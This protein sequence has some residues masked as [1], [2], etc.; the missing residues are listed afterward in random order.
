[1]EIKLLHRVSE[2]GNHYI[3]AEVK[4][5]SGLIGMPMGTGKSKGA[6]RADF[7]RKVDKFL[8]QDVPAIYNTIHNGGL[9]LIKCDE[10]WEPLKEE[11]GE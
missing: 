8:L 5:P 10:Q 3:S 7:N 4:L 6:A 1:M 9:E 11:Q 2:R